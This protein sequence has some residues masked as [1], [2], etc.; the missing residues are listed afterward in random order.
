MLSFLRPWNVRCRQLDPAGLDSSLAFVLDSISKVSYLPGVKAVM[1]D[2]PVW[3]IW[4]ERIQISLLVTSCN[5]DIVQRFGRTYNIHLQGL[6]VAKLNKDLENL[7]NLKMENMCSSETSAS[8]WTTRRYSPECRTLQSH[9]R[10]ILKSNNLKYLYSSYSS[11]F[12][13]VRIFRLQVLLIKAFMVIFVCRLTPKYNHAPLYS[14][15]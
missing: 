2:S 9:R 5:R 3:I 11:W 1:F 13:S 10:E 15:T 7:S 12:R 6:R 8:L 4:N 14:M